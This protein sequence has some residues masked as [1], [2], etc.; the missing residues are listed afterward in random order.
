VSIFAISCVLVN[1][2]VFADEE[3]TV[4]HEKLG[5][6]SSSP[7]AT[8]REEPSRDGEQAESVTVGPNDDNAT[9]TASEATLAEN[10]R[11]TTVVLESEQ[12]TPDFILSTSPPPDTERTEAVTKTSD[13]PNAGARSEANETSLQVKGV[14]IAGKDASSPSSAEP[15]IPAF[16]LRNATR[17]LRQLLRKAAD[18]EE[19]D[20]AT[21]RFTTRAAAT[22]TESPAASRR[23]YL[24][25]RKHGTSSTTVDSSD[26]DV[27]KG[28]LD[29]VT[30]N[31]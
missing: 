1:V 5:N 18:L 11:E 25:E 12:P 24:L 2:P 19:S 31:L 23:R 8:S 30:G 26:E 10:I 15:I 14:V 16:D 29:D 13:H 20:S 17:V 28:P 7:N 22:T 9:T 27:T 4:N 21:A 3:L 6:S